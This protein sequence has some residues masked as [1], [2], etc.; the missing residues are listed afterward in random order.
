MTREG[1]KNPASAGS[2][3]TGRTRRALKVG[4]LTT[5]VG[6]SYLLSALKRPFQSASEQQRELLDTH[7]MGRRVLGRRLGEES[8]ENQE[9][10]LEL[11][12]EIP[13]DRVS[14]SLVSSQPVGAA[15]H[16]AMF[17]WAAEQAG[18]ETVFEGGER[19][20]GHGWRK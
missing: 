15:P 6:G 5:H 1:R 19:G 20:G 4:T 17:L 12:D 10:F 14:V 2:L 11:F 16:L 8:Q 9:Q 18:F 7:T 13:L 3:A